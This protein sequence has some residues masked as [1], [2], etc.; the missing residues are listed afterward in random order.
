VPAEEK[1][2][3]G[4]VFSGLRLGSSV[5]GEKPRGSDLVCGD[6]LSSSCKMNHE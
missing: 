6:L 2:R 5:S 1:R 4:Y 3:G